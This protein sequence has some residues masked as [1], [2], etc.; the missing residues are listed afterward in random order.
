MAKKNFIAYIGWFLQ[1]FILAIF[2]IISIGPFIWVV[3][4]SFKTSN[5]ILSSAFSLPS[6]FNFD[7]YV[8]AVTIS[9]IL[10]FY[11]NSIIIAVSGTFLNVLFVGMAS[12]VLARFNFKFRNALIVVLSVSL[13]LPM[14]ALM[15]PIYMIIKQMGILDTRM[16]LILV[17]TALGLPTTLF[18]MRSFFSALPMIEESA[19]IDGAGF[20]RTYF[21]IVMPIAIPGFATC[22]VLQ[23]LLCWNDFLFALVLTTRESIRTLPLALNYFTS[24]FSYD[25][26]AKFAAIVIV[27]IPSIAFYVVLNEQVV[28]GLTAGSVKE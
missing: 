15:Q 7:G 9:P 24:Q 6:H 20:L 13:F 16:G 10:K 21:Q 12:Y 26:T 11:G 2:I 25:Y 5:E 1:Y 28:S 19:Y 27:I 23:F 18:V 4:S 22:A 3:M 14:T 17:Y 8:K